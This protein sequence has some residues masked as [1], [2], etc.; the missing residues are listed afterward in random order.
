LIKS[1][2]NKIGYR[3][4][5]TADDGKETIEKVKKHM[6][7]L[8][9]LDLQIP[10]MDGF[11]T[12]EYIKKIDRFADTPVIVISDL[13]DIKNKIMA[14][15]CGADDFLA[16][17]LDVIT[18]CA[19]T[20]ATL[21]TSRLKEQ[22]ERLTSLK[23]IT[24]NLFDYKHIF[25]RLVAGLELSR[26]GSLPFSVVYID[27]DYLKMINMEY[28]WEIGDSV[29]KRVREILYQV[30]GK[31]GTVLSSNSDKFLLILPG[32]DEDKVH[33]MTD[34]ILEQVR[35]IPLPA[36]FKRK[37]AFESM[38]GKQQVLT[39]VTLSIGIVTWDKTE[40]LPSDKFLDLVEKALEK[41]Q[42]EGRDKKVQFQFYSE[43]KPGLD[44]KIDKTERKDYERREEF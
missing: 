15:E 42:N 29:I 18:L 32:I 19:R 44:L 36:E 3:N 23:S 7:D 41:A 14:Y 12:C 16:K 26:R 30:I 28:G 38:P 21:Q 4:I 33:V 43:Q 10:E 17:P 5:I 2:L 27:V 24:D 20:K 1:S 37:V 6:P 34:D 13:V 31:N 9:L 22:V 39:R 11:K 40:G 35:K 8:I 25:E